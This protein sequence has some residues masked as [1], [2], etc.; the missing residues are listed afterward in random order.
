MQVNVL[1]YFLETEK[2]HPLRTAVVSGGAGWTFQELGL[3]A[4]VIARRIAASTPCRNTPIAVYLPKS[5]EAIASF[6][7]IVF[8]GNCY[9][10]LDIKMP[11][12]RLET[13]LR[14]LQPALLLTSEELKARL[15]ESGVEPGRLLTLDEISNEGGPEPEAWR[16]TIDTDPLYILHTSGSTGQPKGVVIAHRS[17]I[18][19]IDWAR[20]CFGIDEHAVIGNQ[21]PLIFDNSTLDIYLCLACGASLHFIPEELFLFPVRLLEYLAKHAVNFVF[22]VPSALVNVAKAQIL[23]R[24]PELHLQKILFAGEVMPAKH[25]NVW[26]E[27]F[28]DAVFANL[29]GPTEITVDCTYY[30]VEGHLS[31]DDPVPIG[32]ACRNSSILILNDDNRKCEAGEQGELCVR[33]SSLALG[34]WNQPSQ[35]AAAFVQNP[36]NTHYPELIYRTGDLVYQNQAGD[37]IFVGRKDSQIKHMGYRIE[38]GDVENSALQ[39]AGVQN[40]CVLY[41]LLRKEIVLIYEGAADLDASGVR[42]ELSRRLPKYMWPRVVHRVDELPRNPSGKIDRKQLSS[43]YAS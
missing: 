30:V 32:R 23:D 33:G 42:N 39:V 24:V 19:Y 31:D 38:L 14:N 11:A 10:P 28:P 3:R 27:R 43:Q 1:E 22:W 2:R 16:E 12:A 7:G 13:T 25:L 41:H 15:V 6:L 5:K 36:L 37:I 34:Y 29:Y 18:D 35:T 4:R 8:S 17:V 20:E 40:A 21:A 26:R 9:A